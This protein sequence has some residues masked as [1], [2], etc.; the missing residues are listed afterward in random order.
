MWKY[1]QDK[2]EENLQLLSQGLK[3]AQET[4]SNWHIGVAMRFLAETYQ[5]MTMGNQANSYLENCIVQFQKVQN[6]AWEGYTLCGFG[7]L[8]HQEGGDIELALGLSKQGMEKAEIQK[9]AWIL[10]F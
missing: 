1:D 10:P 4:E 3:I 2:K 5:M 6:E 9:N 7:S 8:Q